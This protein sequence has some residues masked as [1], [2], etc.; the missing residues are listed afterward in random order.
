MGEGSTSGV[1]WGDGLGK[2]DCGRLAREWEPHRDRPEPRGDA[3]GASMTKVDFG[4][5]WQPVKA[6]PG[7]GGWGLRE[8]AVPYSLRMFSP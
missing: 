1:P 7:G 6:H 4:G 3:A 8:C 2:G 5:G